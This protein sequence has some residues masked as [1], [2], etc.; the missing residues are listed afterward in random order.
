MVSGALRAGVSEFSRR[1]RIF[2]NSNVIGLGTEE[3]ES[4]RAAVTPNARAAVARIRTRKGMANLWNEKEG[5]AEATPED[6][7]CSPRL[8]VVLDAEQQRTAAGL[9]L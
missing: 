8:E 9:E 6:C 1:K 2:F 7:K 3:A 4:S 5:V